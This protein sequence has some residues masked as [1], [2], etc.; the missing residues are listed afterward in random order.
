M[1]RGRRGGTGMCCCRVGRDGSV[2]LIGCVGAFPK[3][4]GDV[5][6]G[7]STLPEFQRKG[8]ATEAAAALLE[9]AVGRMS[10]CCR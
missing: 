7:Y 9:L 3:E 10:V 8:Y 2:T 6:I 5:E 1:S 4:A